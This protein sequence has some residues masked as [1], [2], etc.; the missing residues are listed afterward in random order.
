MRLLTPGEFLLIITLQRYN[1]LY[2]DFQDVLTPVCDAQLSCGPQSRL[3]IEFCVELN[4]MSAMKTR[5]GS[6]V[7]GSDESQSEIHTF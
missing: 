1:P 7:F 2:Q 5:H 3:A 4:S 6:K